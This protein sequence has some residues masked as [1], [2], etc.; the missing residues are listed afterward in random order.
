HIENHQS[1]EIP[2]KSEG[3]RFGNEIGTHPQEVPIRTEV[4]QGN[5]ITT[6]RELM[7]EEN[8]QLRKEDHLFKV[9][10]TLKCETE[11]INVYRWRIKVLEQE[12]ER[13]I[14]YFQIQ[15][16]YLKKN[17]N[18]TWN[19]SEFSVEMMALRQLCKAAMCNDS[20]SVLQLP[21]A[22]ILPHCP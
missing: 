17:A 14:D 13:T 4:Y 19:H 5:D 6:C 3:T 16:I 2:M 12:L 1:E 15:I 22:C 7:T 10:D 20:E 11:A 9:D 18:D 21:E 8:C